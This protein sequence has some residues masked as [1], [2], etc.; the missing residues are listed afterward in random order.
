[1]QPRD[2]EHT[3]RRTGVS[4]VGKRMFDLGEQF[5]PEEAPFHTSV[6]VLT[7]QGARAVGAARRHDERY[8]SRQGKSQHQGHSEDAGRV[9]REAG[10]ALGARRHFTT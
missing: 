1:M 6:F 10:E 2:V 4:I 7:S 3:F 5:W 8:L 9:L